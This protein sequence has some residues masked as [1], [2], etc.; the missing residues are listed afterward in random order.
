MMANLYRGDVSMPSN[1]SSA[2]SP[3]TWT[4]VAFWIAWCLGPGVVVWL[5]LGPSVVNMT[6]S[7]ARTEECFML[8]VFAT[9]ALIS[10]T[11]GLV[12]NGPRRRLEYRLV[13]DEV[14]ACDAR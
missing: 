14:R 6:P 12:R 13:R 10:L 1:T 9:S 2:Q 7:H 4:L 3:A 5:A 11:L 8:A